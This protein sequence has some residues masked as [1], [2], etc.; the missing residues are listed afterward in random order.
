MVMQ[1]VWGK[2]EVRLFL[3]KSNSALSVTCL[4]NI[5]SAESS[6]CISYKTGLTAVFLSHE[7]ATLLCN[8]YFVGWMSVSLSVCRRARQFG[9]VSPMGTVIYTYE[10]ILKHK[11]NVSGFNFNYM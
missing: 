7:P 1:I 2:Q 6:I 11:K 5:M 10:T 4:T 9:V 3:P 8:S